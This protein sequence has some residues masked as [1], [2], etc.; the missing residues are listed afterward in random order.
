MEVRFDQNVFLI[1]SRVSYRGNK[2]HFENAF[3][4]MSRV[5]YS[6]SRV[7]YSESGQ[8]FISLGQKIIVFSSRVEGTLLHVLLLHKN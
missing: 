2:N 6:E 1:V 8:E 3:L 4:I 7:S 5:S